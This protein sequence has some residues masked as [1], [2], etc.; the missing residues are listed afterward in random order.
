M[1][2]LKFRYTCQRSNGHIFSH[3]F[4]L[5]QIINGDAKLWDLVNNIG[6]G[7]KRFWRQYTGFK[8]KNG[9]EIYEGDIIKSG[10]YLVLVGWHEKYASFSLKKNGWMFDHFFDEALKP[11]DSEII[12]NIYE[13]PELLEAVS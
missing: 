4:T 6:G 9:K 13:N 2:E 5:E 7:D 8:D 3:D 1:R 11:E 10:D 12:G